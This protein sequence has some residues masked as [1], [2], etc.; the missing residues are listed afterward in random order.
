[1]GADQVSRLVFGWGVPLGIGLL[2]GWI[3]DPV[4]DELWGVY[5]AAFP[6]ATVTATPQGLP[7]GRYAVLMSGT[8]HRACDLDGVF[9]YDRIDTPKPIRTRLAAQ[10]LDG[11][12]NATFPLGEFRTGAP[13]LITPPPTGRLEI[14]MRHRCGERFVMTQATVK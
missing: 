3:V 2:I 10:R 9:A 5:D 6:V 11:A 13:W 12:V 14:W 8:K 7:D 1:M 4:S